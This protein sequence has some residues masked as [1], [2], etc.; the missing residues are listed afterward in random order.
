M[1]IACAYPPAVVVVDGDALNDSVVVLLLTQLVFV[2]NIFGVVEHEDVVNGMHVSVEPN[3]PSDPLVRKPYSFAP[4]V[5]VPSVTSP[6]E[7]PPLILNAPSAIMVAEYPLPALVVTVTSIVGVAVVTDDEERV[8][9][10]ILVPESE[11]E[12]AG[13]SVIAWYPPPTT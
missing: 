5:T 4:A 1:V 11:T 10:A 6:K 7:L 13:M 12:R 2:A 8:P 3:S 9:N